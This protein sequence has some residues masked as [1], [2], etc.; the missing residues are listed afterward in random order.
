M[1]SYEKMRAY[2]DLRARLLE[3]RWNRYLF[4]WL[5]FILIPCIG[6]EYLWYDTY[7]APFAII[8]CVFIVFVDILMEHHIKHYMYHVREA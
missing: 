3:L 8:F 7:F 4:T 2:A 5:S 6:L 1:G